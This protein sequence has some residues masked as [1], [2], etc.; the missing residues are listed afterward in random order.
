MSFGWR[1]KRN[2]RQLKEA[3]M[4][5]LFKI[6]FGL[7]FMSLF[8]YLGTILWQQ[9]FSLTSLLFFAIAL[10]SFFIWFFKKNIVYRF[11]YPGML[12]FLIFTIIPIIFSVFISFTNLGTGHFFSKERVQ[13]IL[14]S[15]KTIVGEGR[16]LNFELYPGPRDQ[17]LLKARSDQETYSTIIDP[18]SQQEEYFLLK[19]KDPTSQEGMKTT[20][21]GFQEVYSRKD[22]L[23]RLIFK[24]PEGDNYIYHRTDKLIK[25]RYLFSLTK[26][27]ELRNNKTMALYKADSDRGQFVNV[28][29]GSALK[30]GFYTFIGLKNFTDLFHKKEFRKTFL[31]VSLWTFV[32]A[33][34]SVILTFSLGLSLALFINDKN[35]A[36]KRLYRNLLILP[37]SI[38]F[39][40]SVLVFKGMLNKDFGVINHALSQV[41]INAIPWL[42]NGTWAKISCLLVNLWLGFPYMFLLTT[43]ILQSIPE[44][45]YE[46][47]KIDGANKWQSFRNITLPLILSSITPLLIGAFAFN[48]GNF[49]GIYL[50]TGGGP[51]MADATT[52]AGQTD[53]LI[54]Y[55][56]RLAFEGAMGQQ[57]GL[58]SSI[59]LFIFLIIGALTALN[60][61]V[62]NKE[63]EL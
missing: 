22:V 4:F 48:L 11:L 2:L 54:S 8:S 50:L 21:F 37:Y 25:G 56:Y 32:W 43:G 42:E 6:I 58:A 7:F 10:I 57:F 3:I 60:F 62:F 19:A 14:L 40:I 36:F 45:V 59:A 28:D 39:F 51:A 16:A 5:K 9:G 27:G 35:L 41:G 15:E 20:P 52:P 26:E 13:S 63:Q 23:K 31:K 30:P 46:A 55:T 34:V 61:K 47:A 24:L 38:P 12:A 53:I 29:N 17:W 1:G 18:Q 33:L 49:V 44:S